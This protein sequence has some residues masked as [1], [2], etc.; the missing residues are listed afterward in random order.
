MK[1]GANE[2]DGFKPGDVISVSDYRDAFEP[3]GKKLKEGEV[4]KL[5]VK[6]NKEFI[7]LEIK[8]KYGMKQKRHALRWSNQ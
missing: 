1:T 8:A 4:A 6:R 3:N 5:R 7:T 2:W